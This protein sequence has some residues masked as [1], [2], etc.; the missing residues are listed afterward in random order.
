MNGYTDGYCSYDSVDAN[1]AI[2]EGKIYHGTD[3]RGKTE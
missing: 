2:T 1:G 3:M